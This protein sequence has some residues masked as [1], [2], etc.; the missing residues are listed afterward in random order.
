MAFVLHPNQYVPGAG[1]LLC[2]DEVVITA[3][4]ARALSSRLPELDSITGA[5]M[6]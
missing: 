3:D 5:V 2:G 1:Y 6:A 4:G